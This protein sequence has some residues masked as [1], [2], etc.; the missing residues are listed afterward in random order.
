M[1]SAQGVPPGLAVW[2]TAPSPCLCLALGASPE[3]VQWA[4]PL[5]RP[6]GSAY[7]LHPEMPSGHG[8]GQAWVASLLSQSAPSTSIQV[9]K[10]QGWVGT[11]GRGAGGPAALPPQ[12]P[13]MA[14]LVERGLGVRLPGFKS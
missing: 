14:L 3:G 4:E 11:L 5:C 9:S 7:P 13:L 12:Y 8:A 2:P 10:C 6:F 1:S